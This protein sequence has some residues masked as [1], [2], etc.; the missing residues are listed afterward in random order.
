MNTYGK[1]QMLVMFN[2]K[3]PGLAFILALLFGSFGFLYTSVI[4]GIILILLELAL[5]LV[6]VATL[7]LGLLL[8]FL[9]HIIIAVLGFEL[10]RMHNKKLINDYLAKTGG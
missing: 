8:V 7:G 4:G 6:G 10:C 2:A 5:C 9:Y 3:N 1:E